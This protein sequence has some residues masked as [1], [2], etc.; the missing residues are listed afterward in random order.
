[1]VT[2]ILINQKITLKK[3]NFSENFKFSFF[4]ELN[5]NELIELTNLEAKNVEDSKKRQFSDPIY[6]KD[7][8]IKLQIFKKKIKRKKNY[9]L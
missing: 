6:W 8:K 9:Y 4:S 7:T 3:I 2:I 5:D 1:M